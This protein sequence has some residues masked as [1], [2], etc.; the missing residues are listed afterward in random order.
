MVHLKKNLMT[1][2][3]YFFAHTNSK[4]S[5][6][7]YPFLVQNMLKF[8]LFRIKNIFCSFWWQW[9]PPAFE[10][11]LIIHSS[12]SFLLFTLG[13]VQFPGP[14]SEK[15]SIHIDSEEQYILSPVM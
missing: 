8:I 9:M 4:G 11:L 3:L 14:L 1:I 2:L 6:S 12:Q 15:L 13:S 10:K 5:A 7:L